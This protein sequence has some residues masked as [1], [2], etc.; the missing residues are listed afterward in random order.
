MNLRDYLISRGITPK[1]EERIMNEAISDLKIEPKIIND[2]SFVEKW[3]TDEI[4]LYLKNNTIPD[5]PIQL[6][7]FT[8][9]IDPEKFISTHLMI[10]TSKNGNTGYKP[11]F[12][13]LQT[14]IKGLNA[15]NAE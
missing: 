15:K 9:I 14:F 8:T 2:A 12:D 5:G 6:N 13:R 1:G 10:A 4:E 7:R 11:Y 3:N